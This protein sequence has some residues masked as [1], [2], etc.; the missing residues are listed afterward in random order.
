[1]TVYKLL[2]NKNISIAMNYTNGVMIKSKNYV[3]SGVFDQ[4][5]FLGL[6]WAVT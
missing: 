5:D 1:M 2:F 4:F 3:D 6:F